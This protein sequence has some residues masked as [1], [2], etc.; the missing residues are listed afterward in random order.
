MHSCGTKVDSKHSLVIHGN[1]DV[2]DQG[3]HRW[4]HPALCTD[5]LLFD[6]HPGTKER[7]EESG[8]GAGQ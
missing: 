2:C 5:G 6:Y 7:S 3:W 8:E 4:Q 1:D